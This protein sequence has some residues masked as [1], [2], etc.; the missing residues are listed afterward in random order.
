MIWEIISVL[1]F[2]LVMYLGKRFKTLLLGE[3][4]IGFL[5]GL[6]WEFSASPL[7]LYKGFTIWIYDVPLAIL[8]LWGVVVAGFI[9]ISNLLR[10]YLGFETLTG[11]LLCDVLVAGTLG[12]VMEYVGSHQL[13][14]WTYPT[15]TVLHPILDVPTAWVQGWWITVGLLI[16]TFARVYDKIFEKEIYAL[17]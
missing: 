9:L 5:W 13:G 7:F 3:F 14:M 10:T 16:T 11:R 2:L 8:I 15:G 12:T 17:A 1:A 6:Y 4:I